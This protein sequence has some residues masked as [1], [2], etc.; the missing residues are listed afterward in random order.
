MDV[1]R[2]AP[3][4][5]ASLVRRLLRAARRLQRRWLPRPIDRLLAVDGWTH[6]SQLRFLMAQARAL[7]D[8]SRLVELGVWQGRSALALGEACRGT[9]KRV[10]AVDPWADY[11]EGG[12]PVSAFLARHGVTSFEEV[13]R[14]F[15]AHRR[16]LG[17]ESWVTAVRAESVAAAAR[18]AEGPVALLFVDA[19]HRYEAVVADLDAWLPHVAPGG[20]VCGDDWTWASVQRAVREVAAR[21]GRR[22]E[23]PC[24]NTWAFRA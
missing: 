4:P 23:V 10:F 19:N 24:Q 13:H 3:A 9:R 22:V 16:R 15:E 6:A 18:W 12:G 20:L 14:R 2:T 17:L 8:G 7:P 11:D 1:A 5:P 21:R